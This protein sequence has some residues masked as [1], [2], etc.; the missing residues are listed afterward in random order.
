MVFSYRPEAILYRVVFNVFFF[1]TVVNCVIYV[2]VINIISYQSAV[3]IN[4]SL[5][6]ST[7]LSEYI[8]H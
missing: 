8:F 5:E 7:S 2:Y 3:V 1:F 4:Y 6:F